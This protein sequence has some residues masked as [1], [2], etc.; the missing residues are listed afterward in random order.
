MKING[1]DIKDIIKKVLSNK[2]NLICVIAGTVIIILLIILLF[3]NFK[4]VKIVKSSA[5][6]IQLVKYENENF[7]MNI[8][9]GWVVETGGYDMFYAIRVYNPNDNRYQIFSI[10]KAEPFLK[11]DKAKKWYQNYYKSFGGSGNKVLAEAIVLYKPTVEAFYSSF[12]EYASYTKKVDTMYNN[13]K[14]PDLKNFAVVEKFESNS[15]MKSVSKDDKT[16]RATFQDSVTGKVGEGLFMGSLV[17]NGSY[18]ALGY[19]TLFYTMYNVMGISAGEYDLINYGSI[20]TN[21][22][23]S[24]AYK[25]SFV[26]TTIKNGN[27]RTKSA[28]AINASINEAF[29]SYNKA[30]SARQKSYDITSQKYS[31]ATLG[32]ERVIDTKTGEIYKAYNGF[33]DEYKGT[34]YES[35]TDTMYTEAVN[36]YIER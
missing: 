7:T 5:S 21:S 4:K 16:L 1:K 35:V 27:E 32:Y 3:G 34:R 13:F 15:S 33:L 8:P 36:G 28:L 23:N 12:N 25:D 30:W 19:D 17:N 14:F 29:D 24:L 10:L 2:K 20:L 11:N 6:S 9:K 26:T 31:D 18:M 22:L